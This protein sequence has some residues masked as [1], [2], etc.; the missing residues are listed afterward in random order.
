MKSSK[1]LKTIAMIASLAVVSTVVAAQEFP[2]K[3]VQII[4]PFPAGMASDIVARV[5][6]NGLGSL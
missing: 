4:V 1:T 2:E 6:A 3:P 5:V